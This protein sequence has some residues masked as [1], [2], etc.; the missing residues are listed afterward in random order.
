[1]RLLLTVVGLLLAGLITAGCEDGRTDPPN[2][3]LRVIH[4]MPTLGPVI[5]RRVR[6]N[7]TN[8][9][10][11][12]SAGFSFDVDT[13]T[14]NLEI[15]APDG[16]VAQTISLE[17][18]LEQG[19]DYALVLRDI[20]GLPS[21]RFIETPARSTSTAGTQLQLMH[22][23]LTVGAVDVYLDVEGFDLAT[24]EPW[25]SVGYDELI[26]PRIVAAPDD[27]VFI[28]TEA[29]NKANVLLTTGPVNLGAT[30][31]LFILLADGANEGLAPITLTIAESS[32]VDLVDQ[33]LQSGIRVINSVGDRSAIDAGIDLELDPPLIP[34][35]AFG[36]VS[37][38]AL[39]APGDHDFNVTPAGNPGV[40][41]IEQP[42]SI[43]KADVATW[44][45]SGSP[46]DLDFIFLDDNFRVPVGE[47]KLRIFQGSPAN[48]SVQ[49]FVT[50]PGTNLSTVP[51]TSLLP[52]G[53]ASPNIRMAPN[54][55]ELTVRSATGTVLAGPVAISIET[56]G[57]YG[58][59]LS[60]PLSGSGVDI[61]YLYDF[62]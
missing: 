25:D 28:V 12:N 30:Q 11:K 31:N 29:G 61:T 33:G 1:M 45:I 52:A 7:T 44:L 13:Y 58:I 59:L 43:S 16:S 47:S 21:A 42:F 40:L 24:A 36:T 5:F 60:D 41:E 8:L 3:S 57:Y 22:T 56:D 27:Y 54:D 14:F 49:V 15:V 4:A 32:G 62:N 55:Y 37:D 6:S 23:A 50:A 17:R 53:T 20:G 46:G 34:G 26:P 51:A 38:L 9:D 39:L 2:A 10:Y 18:M 48:P 19:T 35:I